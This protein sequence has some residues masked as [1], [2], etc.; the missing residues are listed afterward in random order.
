[1]PDHSHIGVGCEIHT[2][3]LWLDKYEEI[4]EANGYSEDEINEYGEILRFVSRLME[5]RFSANGES[6]E[7]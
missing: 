7:R 6:D 2:A 4:G 5:M 1:M 3:R